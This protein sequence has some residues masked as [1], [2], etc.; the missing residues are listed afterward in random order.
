MV[1]MLVV[2][3]PIFC[4]A[5]GLDDGFDPADQSVRKSIAALLTEIN[6]LFSTEYELVVQGYGNKPI[7]YVR[8]PKT[9]SDDSLRSTK[10]WLDIAIG[11]SGSKEGDTF[12]SAYRIANHLLRF[13][14]DSVLAACETQRIAVCKPMT[15]TGY[16]AMIKA[17]KITGVGER[18][19]QKYLSAELG[20]GFCPSRRSVDILS[21]GHVEIKYNSINFTFDGKQEE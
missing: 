20:H 17:A 8:V 10:E 19:V 15:A 1:T 14:K 2:R 13:Y 11:I 6:S 5:L 18:E 21:D 12:N 7:N 16:T 4:R 9:S 3:F